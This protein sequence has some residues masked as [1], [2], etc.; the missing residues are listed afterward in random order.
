M[1]NAIGD[2][3]SDLA[4][5]QDEEDG[6]DKDDDGEDTGQGK[7]SDDDEAGWV[8]GTIS[9]AVQ[10]HRESYRQKK[11]RLDELTQLGWGDM[12]DHFRQRDI[13]HG[14]TELKVPADGKPQTVSTGATPWPTTFG[15]LME[16]IDIVPGQSQIPQVTS[17]QGSSQMR[18]CSEKP[19]AENHMVPPMPTTVPDLS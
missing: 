10:H 6:E 13:K 5:S 1:L 11:T 2:S 19:Q 7:L 12:A 9:K 14:T 16:A 3:L 17:P 18:L 15:E 8:M 4:S